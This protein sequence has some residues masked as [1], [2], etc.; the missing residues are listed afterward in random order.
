MADQM[1][2]LMDDVFAEEDDF[3]EH[4]GRSGLDGAP[5]GSGRYRYGSGDSASVCA[6]A[7]GLKS[8]ARGN[9][10]ETIVW[11]ESQ[12]EGVVGSC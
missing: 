12:G 10:G 9:E 4:V 3:L 8:K 5:I 2:I 11:N 1:Y 7:S 6:I